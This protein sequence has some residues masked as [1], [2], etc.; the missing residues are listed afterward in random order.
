MKKSIDVLEKLSLELNN[1]TTFYKFN[2]N[3]EASD[4]Y[5]K[6]RVDA[7]LWLNDLIFYFVQKEKSFL[8]EFNEQ[9]QKQKKKL[10]NLKDGD[11]KQG[12]YDELNLI[13][14]DINDRIHS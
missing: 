9:I 5:R 7:S 10:D 4:K 3:I 11:Y 1:H 6:G 13:E 8:G 12:L 2:K 14:D